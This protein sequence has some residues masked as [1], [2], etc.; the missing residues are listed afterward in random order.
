MSKNLI[1]EEVVRS[2]E[3]SESGKKKKDT[4]RHIEYNTPDRNRNRTRRPEP[5]NQNH[6]PERQN[7]PIPPIPPQ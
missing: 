1:L 5:E 4:Q 3:R 2:A 6:K 7:P